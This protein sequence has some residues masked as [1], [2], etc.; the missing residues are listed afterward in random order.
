MPEQQSREQVARH[1]PCSR[2]RALRVS[3]VVAALLFISDSALGSENEKEKELSGTQ[4]V[5]GFLLL[6]GAI[7]ANALLASSN[8]RVYG[9]FVTLV[10]PVAG[11][12]TA[13][14]STGEAGRWITAGTLA[15]LGIYHMTALDPERM[16]KS[17]IRKKSFVA[18][19]ATLIPLGLTELVLAEPKS[20]AKLSFSVDA[21]RHEPMIVFSYRF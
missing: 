13:P 15:V 14:P 17:E 6:E 12:V 2:R 21:I 8:P 9:G 3:C 4:Y 10:L 18:W 19:N 1:E 11:Y 20:P 16:T 5:T 7:A